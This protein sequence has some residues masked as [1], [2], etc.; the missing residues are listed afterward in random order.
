MVDDN[1]TRIGTNVDC[2]GKEI[3]DQSVF[4]DWS[5][6]ILSK[7]VLPQISG[8]YIRPATAGG[9]LNLPAEITLAW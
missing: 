4:E 3:L 6:V 8:L 2:F 5:I 9:A 7:P 1:K